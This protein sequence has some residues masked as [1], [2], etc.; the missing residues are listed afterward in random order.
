MFPGGQRQ[1]PS[2]VIIGWKHFLQKHL[3]HQGLN[4]AELEEMIQTYMSP[5]LT[6]WL[7]EQPLLL[8]IWI[9]ASAQLFLGK[10]KPETVIY[11]VYVCCSLLMSIYNLWVQNYSSGKINKTIS[12]VFSKQVAGKH[13][14]S[15]HSPVYCKS[16]LSINSYALSSDQELLV[17]I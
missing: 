13:S 1:L 3:S 12:R 9:R 16:V 4:K 10:L 15:P 5:L 7:G 11:Q 17:K 2:R 14:I 6:P 8:C